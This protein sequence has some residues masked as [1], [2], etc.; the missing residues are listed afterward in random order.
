MAYPVEGA[1][2]AAHPVALPMLEIKVANKLPGG[3][4]ASLR[5]ASGASYSFHYDLLNAWQP[6]RPAYLVKHCIN[7]GRQCDGY[8]VDRHRP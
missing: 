7:E 5:Y 2:P 6:T 1:C 3:I 4:T 8:G